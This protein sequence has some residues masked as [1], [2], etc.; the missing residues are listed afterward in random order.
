MLGKADLQ[1]HKGKFIYISMQRLMSVF[2]SSLYQSESELYLYPK[3][4]WDKC[5]AADPLLGLRR[6]GGGRG[7]QGMVHILTVKKVDRPTI[8]RD[9]PP[10][11]V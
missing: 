1:N 5:G 10:C 8:L 6:G 7:T 11:L 2:R 3:G 4:Q 9:D